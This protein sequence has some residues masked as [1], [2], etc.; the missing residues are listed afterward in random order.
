GVV[1][2]AGPAPERRT[3]KDVE[4]LRV[5]LGEG[6][7]NPPRIYEPPVGAVSVDKPLEPTQPQLGGGLAG[8]MAG[9]RLAFG[10]ARDDSAQPEG[11][12]A[13]DPMLRTLSHCISGKQ[14]LR[15]TAPGAADVRAALSLAREFKL[16]L[17]LVDVN[18]NA[19]TAAE[20]TEAKDLI[21]GVIVNP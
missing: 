16:K 2:L 4:S 14:P 3:L 17:L 20:W 5:L 1:K 12:R 21:A 7:K 15:V 6:F 18:P 8:G 19:L 13:T 10:A 9:L 11:S